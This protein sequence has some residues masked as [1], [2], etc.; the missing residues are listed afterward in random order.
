MV[1]KTAAAV[2]GTIVAALTAPSEGETGVNSFRFISTGS[3]GNFEGGSGGNTIFTDGP[4]MA[5]STIFMISATM[6]GTHQTQ[7]SV[8]TQVAQAANTAG[9]GASGAGSHMF[10]GADGSTGTLGMTIAFWGVTEHL[11]TGTDLTNLK[12]F[13]NTNWGTSF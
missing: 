8:T 4:S 6:D 11:L 13:S 1:L 3:G 7:Y 12:N 10:C 9:R 2:N 5:A